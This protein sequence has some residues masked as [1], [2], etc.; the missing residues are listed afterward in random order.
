M[1]RPLNQTAF[2]YS[3]YFL[4]ENNG[5]YS[6]Q[7]PDNSTTG[8]DSRGQGAVDF[9][10]TRTSRDQVAS[11]V[12]SF[13][14]NSSNKASGPY[15]SAFGSGT[16]ASGD[17]SFA[18]GSG[19]TASGAYSF[20]CGTNGTASGA[21][22]FSAGAG[23]TASGDYSFAVTNGAG[24]SGTHSVSVGIGAS[25]SGAYAV[26]LGSFSTASGTDSV[27]ISSRSTADATGSAVLGGLYGITRGIQGYTVFPACSQPIAATAGVSQSARLVLAVQTTDATATVLRSNSSAAGTSNQVILPNNSAYS[28]RG[29]I[30][31]NVTGAGNTKG[32]VIEGAIKR[33][34][35]AAST[36]MVGTPTVTSN[37]ADAGASTWTVA[38][39]A[40]TTNG[41]IKIEV[42]GQAATTI[43]WCCTVETSEV[44]F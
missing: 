30:I 22:S 36:T 26:A 31:A 3:Q 27:C 42:T 35:N 17:G 28:F 23:C 43:R 5:G 38:V 25:A 40:D 10:S 8:G 21:S 32:W 6:I 39:T 13:A 44:T 7:I 33:G 34:A 9:Q 4:V 41:G 37:Y 16:T 14:A 12:G 1:P 24:A 19:S 29:N 11:G 18:S 15:S 2:D 20:C